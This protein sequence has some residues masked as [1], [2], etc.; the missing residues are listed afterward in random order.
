MG[1]DLYHLTENIEVDYKLLFCKGFNNSDHFYLTNKC[2]IY[3]GFF[4]AR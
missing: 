4:S 2:K 3:T 1:S